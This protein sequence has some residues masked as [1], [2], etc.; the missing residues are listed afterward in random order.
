M[1]PAYPRSITF[2]DAKQQT[3]TMRIYVGG[4]DAAAAAANLDPIVAAVAA[5]SNATVRAEVDAAVA[6]VAGTAAALEDVED[7]G[8]I[9]F[10]TSAGSLHR[11]SIAAPKIVMFQADEETVDFGL[12]AVGAFVT[13]MLNGAVSRD[14]LGFTSA[15]GGYRD[16]V[17]TQRKFNIFTRNPA[18]TG[19][20]L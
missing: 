15:V 14:G 3:S 7:K 1:A 10:Q 5:L 4:A 12:A 19:Q 2:R 17:R 20:G 18:L 9:V 8:T 16:R 13:A 6:Q 11:Y